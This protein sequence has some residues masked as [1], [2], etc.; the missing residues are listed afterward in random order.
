[1][2]LWNLFYETA[3]QTCDAIVANIYGDD[4][5]I[6]V[7]ADQYEQVIAQ[8]PS[9]FTVTIHQSF[10]SYPQLEVIA[11]LQKI[12]RLVVTDEGRVILECDVKSM[13]TAVSYAQ[14]IWNGA[15][16][17]EALQIAI[18]VG[19]GMYGEEFV[20]SVLDGIEEQVVMNY[21]MKAGLKD[22]LQFTSMKL[23]IKELSIALTE[24]AMT[25]SV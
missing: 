22:E 24:K 20:E 4:S 18:A 23:T 10:F 12:D 13:S 2:Q 5:H 1:M 16:N 19:M 9:D 21:A 6:E 14:S 17:E 11:S 15:T 3:Q 8:L 7:S 25:T